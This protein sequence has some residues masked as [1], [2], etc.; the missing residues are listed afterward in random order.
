MQQ[1]VAIAVGGDD[2]NLQM[3]LLYHQQEECGKNGVTEVLQCSGV[4]PSAMQDRPAK[5][6]GIEPSGEVEEQLTMEARSKGR[7]ESGKELA[8]RAAHQQ[9]T[10]LWYS[11]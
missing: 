1:V 10:G 9:L 5:W 4:Q 11:T 7:K 8:H 6:A 3:L 2:D